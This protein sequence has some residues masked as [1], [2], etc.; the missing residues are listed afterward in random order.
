MPQNPYNEPPT[1]LGKIL[2]LVYGIDNRPYDTVEMLWTKVAR[3]LG[4]T[5]SEADDLEVILSRVV[6]AGGSPSPSPTPSEEVIV[7]QPD[8]ETFFS[9]VSFISYDN[10]PGLVGVTDIVFKMTNIRGTIDLEFTDDLVSVSFPN[11]VSVGDGTAPTYIWL[12]VGTAFT[13]FSAPLLTT[14]NPSSGPAFK[15]GVMSLL[16]T[17]S[18][19]SVVTMTG[20]VAALANPLLANVSFPLWIPTPGKNV[21]FSDNA[22]T[23]ASVNHLLARCVASP[24]WGNAGENLDLQG[25]GNAA[26]TGQGILDKATLI[27]RGANV[28]TN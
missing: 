27:G 1:T 10:I 11:L 9:E 12:A 15:I 18:L 17:L 20:E 13:S 23:A 22:L 2:N 16:T 21:L 5:I 14:I 7:A 4:A 26:P 8:N 24:T 25:A 19:P 28:S 3:S 6:D